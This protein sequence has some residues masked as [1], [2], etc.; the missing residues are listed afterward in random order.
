MS[1]CSC[2]T[3]HQKIYQCP[4]NSAESLI[5]VL[6]LSVFIYHLLFIHK[7]LNSKNFQEFKKIVY[8]VISDF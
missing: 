4:R 3:H 1:Y 8:S 2:M 5:F 6:H 7:N